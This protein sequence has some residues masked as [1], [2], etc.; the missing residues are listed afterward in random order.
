[1]FITFHARDNKYLKT[2]YPLRDWSYHDYRDSN[3]TNYSSAINDMYCNYKFK[4]VRIGKFTNSNLENTKVILDYAN[5]HEYTDVGEMLLV[6]YSKLLVCSDSGASIFAEY[7][8]KPIVY[9]N[10]S[11]PLRISRWHPKSIFIFKKVF[12]KDKMKYLSFRDLFN[13]NFEDKYFKYKYEIHENSSADIRSAI[14]EQIQRIDRNWID[15]SE[16]IYLQNRFWNLFG[17][18]DYSREGI[19]IGSSFLSNNQYLIE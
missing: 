3:V 10:W 4:G 7:I 12:S 11:N 9:V 2:I 17:D 6:Y 16:N 15:T 8:N 5:H 19:F 13:I 1:M 14:E 18:Y